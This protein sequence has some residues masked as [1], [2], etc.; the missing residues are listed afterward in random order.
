PLGDADLVE[1]IRGP[2]V[3]FG[4]NTLGAS[5]NILTRRGQERLELVPEVAGGSFGRQDYTLRLGG[6]VKPFDYS[7]RLRYTPHAACA[8]PP[9][10]PARLATGPAASAPTRP[11]RS[12]TAPTTHPAPLPISPAPPTPPDT[13]PAG[14]FS[15]PRLNLGIINAKYAVTD[16]LAAE[17]NAFVR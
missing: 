4:R 15:P 12:P 7:L 3:L 1:V 11:H 17:A 14:D 5:I 8:R 16:K 9:R 6:A 2:S 10:P 13:S